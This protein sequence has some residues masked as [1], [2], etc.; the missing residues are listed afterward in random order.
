LILVLHWKIVPA[1]RLRDQDQ[2]AN[3]DFYSDP[4][5]PSG[6]TG[7]PWGTLLHH[8][9]LFA[10]G[11]RGSVLPG[12]RLLLVEQFDPGPVLEL[13]ESYRASTML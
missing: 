4:T 5:Y 2:G 10:S 7:C 9:A 1:Y 3:N 13:M 8:R 6:T 11:D 12:G